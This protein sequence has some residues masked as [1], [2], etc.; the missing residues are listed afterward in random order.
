MEFHELQVWLPGRGAL[1]QLFRADSL[2][3]ALE[4]ARYKYPGALVEV[5]APAAKKPR[6][7][8]AHTCP[9]AAA[10]A[11]LKL[12]QEKET[13]AAQAQWAKEAWERVQ[14]DQ[15]RVDFVEKLYVEADRANAELPYRGTYTGLY[16][17]YLE[18]L[19]TGE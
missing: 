1:R 11:R 19:D 13:M 16:Q 9:K 5:P 10:R 3:R 17:Q 8:R 4:I 2:A 15:A 7:V 6:L 14:A 12:V 18:K